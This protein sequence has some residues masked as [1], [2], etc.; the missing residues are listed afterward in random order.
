MSLTLITAPHNGK[1]LYKLVSLMARPGIRAVTRC[2]KSKT[3][4]NSKSE[5]PRVLYPYLI[6]YD[7]CFFNDMQRP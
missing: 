1:I 3:Q 5:S 4:A 2:D 7:D 6:G